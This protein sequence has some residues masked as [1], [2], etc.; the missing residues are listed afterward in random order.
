MVAIMAVLEFP[1]KLSF[2][3]HVSVESLYGMYT[4]SLLP[5][6]RSESKE[7]TFPKECRDLLILAPSYTQSTLKTS[8]DNYF[9]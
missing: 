3:S 2:R 7:M 9:R 8:D 4:F 5:V 6:E 1:P